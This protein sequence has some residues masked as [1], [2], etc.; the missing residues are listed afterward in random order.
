MGTALSDMTGR[1]GPGHFLGAG[2]DVSDVFDRLSGTVTS[3]AD[4]LAFLEA[5]LADDDVTDWTRPVEDYLDALLTWLRSPEGR[6]RMASYPNEFSALAAAFYAG[7]NRRGVP[8]A[9][10][11]S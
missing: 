1:P 9:G 3:E 6:Q 4:F 11:P 2:G 7:I 8:D 5:L 10:S